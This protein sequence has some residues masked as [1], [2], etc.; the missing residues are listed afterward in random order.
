MER[1]KVPY[2]CAIFV[3]TLVQL[4]SAR[5][6]R[7]RARRPLNTDVTLRRNFLFCDSI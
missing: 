4:S 7:D 5:I 2:S 1:G 6:E 3:G